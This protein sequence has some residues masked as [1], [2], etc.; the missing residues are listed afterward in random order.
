MRAGAGYV[1]A[2]VPSSLNAIFETRLLEVMTVPLPDAGGVF[3]FQRSRARR[4]GAARAFKHWCSARASGASR[5]RV[6]FARRLAA[7]AEVPLLLDADG[8]NAYAGALEALA[9]RD[10]A[11]GAHAARGRARPAARPE[12]R[13]R[14]VTSAAQRAR[15]RPRRPTRSWC[16][17]ATTQ[18]SPS[19][20]AESR[21]SRGGAP[22]LAT[23][24]TGD[25]LSGVIGAYL[26]KSMDPFHAACAGVF[27]HAAAGRLAAR[28]D[29]PG[30]GD[31]ARRDRAAATSA[32]GIRWRP[33]CIERSE[34]YAESHR[35]RRRHHPYGHS[36]CPRRG[37]SPPGRRRSWQLSGS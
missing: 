7:A 13:R 28:G 31:R 8:L 36:R 22:A 18:S 30:G 26:A 14:P 29:R 24:G 35:H 20:T 10:A 9:E 3:E 21:I 34:H 15:P 37:Q 11:D 2:C 12:R 17:R 16:S 4:S 6:V 25:V 19:R 5:R 27:V 1:T 32:A 23:A 33:G